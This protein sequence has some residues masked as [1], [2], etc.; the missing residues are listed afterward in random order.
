MKKEVDWAETYKRFGV[1]RDNVE[2]RSRVVYFC[3]GCGS[4]VECNYLNVI[5]SQ[6]PLCR[7]CNHTK[8]SIEPHERYPLYASELCLKCGGMKKIADSHS[9]F[10]AECQ[11]KIKQRKRRLANIAERGVL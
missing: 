11:K 3:P 2:Q 10:C 5:T 7:S 6:S 9:S 1:R 4:P 8:Q